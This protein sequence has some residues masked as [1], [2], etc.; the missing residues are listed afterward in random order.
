MRQ[1]NTQKDCRNAY[2]LRESRARRC[3]DRVANHG[4]DEEGDEE[5]EE[6]KT[7]RKLER[8]EP[9]AVPLV[10]KADRSPRAESAVELKDTPSGDRGSLF[11]LTISLSSPQTRLRRR[12]CSRR[13]VSHGRPQQGRKGGTCACYLH[14]RTSPPS[15]TARSLVLYRALPNRRA[16][17]ERCAPVLVVRHPRFLDRCGTFI[18]MAGYPLLSLCQSRSKRPS[19]SSYSTTLTETSTLGCLLYTPLF[20]RSPRRWTFDYRLWQPRRTAESIR[21]SPSKRT[22]Q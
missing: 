16:C 14:L 18:Y 21:S 13:V 2:S 3:R 1:K 12:P 17:L 5:E 11:L 7:D 22:G 10:P 15:F 9:A 20:P 6:E 19:S 8:R 4:Q